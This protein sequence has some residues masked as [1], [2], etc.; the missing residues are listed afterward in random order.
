MSVTQTNS[1]C[2]TCAVSAAFL[3]AGRLCFCWHGSAGRGVDALCNLR[4]RSR[5]THRR[6]E[7]EEDVALERKLALFMPELFWLQGEEASTQREHLIFS[8]Y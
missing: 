1:G 6:G 8:Q 4:L 5:G 3:L 2:S 7:R